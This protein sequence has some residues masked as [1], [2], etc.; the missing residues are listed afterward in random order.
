MVL[1]CLSA[2]TAKQ[3]ILSSMSV[4]TC[5]WGS[6]SSTFLRASSMALRMLLVERT[7]FRIRII[8]PLSV[9]NDGGR[10]LEMRSVV[11]PGKDLSQ[12][13]EIALRKVDLGGEHR[14]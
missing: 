5:S 4:H 7:P 13:F 2:S 14:H 10:Y 6:M 12:P 9:A 1:S 11:S 3:Y 8:C